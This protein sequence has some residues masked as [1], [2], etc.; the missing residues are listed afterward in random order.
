[1]FGRLAE[2]IEAVRS[3]GIEFEV[4]PGITAATA[5]AA[6]AGISLTARGR[7][8][9]VCRDRN[10]PEREAPLE[11]D[12]DGLARLD[13]TLIFYMAVRTLETITNRLVALGRDPGE[14]ALER[15]GMVGERLVRTAGRHGRH[16]L[17]GRGDIA[18]APD[19]RPDRGARVAVGAGGRA[20]PAREPRH[21]TRR[22]PPGPSPESDVEVVG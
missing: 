10:R 14:P 17:G 3:A 20:T 15:A 8:S 5:A 4:I 21:L 9:L 22:T 13:G 16:R 7:S 12:W 19:H 18:G 11:L 2:E 1:M 6:R